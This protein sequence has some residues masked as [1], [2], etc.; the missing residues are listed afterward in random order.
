MHLFMKGN[1][2]LSEQDPRS[3]GPRG[4][5][6]IG[7]MKGIHETQTPRR[8]MRMPTP[9]RRNTRV[10]WP[11]RDTNGTSEAAASAAYTN[12]QAPN[13]SVTVAPSALMNCAIHAGCAGHAGAVIRCPSVTA[14]STAIS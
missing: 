5:V 3:Q 6:F 14:L 11:V 12:G 4:I 1:I 13:Q 9:P 7:N 2:E 8:K 10:A